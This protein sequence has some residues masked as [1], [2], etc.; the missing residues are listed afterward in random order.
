M[1]GNCSLT[2]FGNISEFQ[3]RSVL[4]KDFQAGML[5][6]Y[7]SKSFDFDICKGERSQT[8]L[9]LFRSFGSYAINLSLSNF[10]IEGLIVNEFVVLECKGKG[11]CNL[12]PLCLLLSAHI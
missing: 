8:V 11:Q 7:V 9:C 2:M 5:H 1:P 4:L 10:S 12:K 6:D 3:R